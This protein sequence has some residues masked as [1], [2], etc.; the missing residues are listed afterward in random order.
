MTA[1]LD[2]GLSGRDNL[3]CRSPKDFPSQILFNC[4]IGF[5]WEN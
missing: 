2:G 5:R 1:I 3:K 4:H